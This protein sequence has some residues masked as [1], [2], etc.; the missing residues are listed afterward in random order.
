MFCTRIKYT[1]GE[2]RKFCLGLRLFSANP[3]LKNLILSCVYLHIDCLEYHKCVLTLSKTWSSREEP[4]PGKLYCVTGWFEVFN[5]ILECLPFDRNV[6]LGFP[7]RNGRRSTS[8][9]QNCNSCYELNPKKVSTRVGL[10]P[11]NW[12]MLN[13]ITLNWYHRNEGTSY[14]RSSQCSVNISQKWPCR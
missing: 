10:K 13:N 1:K 12:Q 7:K 11:R 8:S 5:L 9:P 14:K 3:G 2:N 4:G 6:R